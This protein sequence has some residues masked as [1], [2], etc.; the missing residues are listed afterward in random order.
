VGGLALAIVMIATLGCSSSAVVTP[1]AHVGSDAG[2]ASEAATGTDADARTDTG[3]DAAPDSAM[4][5]PADATTDAP[6]SDALTEAPAGDAAKDAG[7]APAG[8]GGADGDAAPSCGFTPSNPASTGL[9]NTAVYMASTD[10]ESDNVTGLYW[11]RAASAST[12]T[13]ADAATLCA[14]KGMGWRLPTLVELASLVDYTIAPPGPTINAAFPGTPSDYFW[15]SSPYVDSAGSGWVINFSSGRTNYLAVG[16]KA[17]VRCVRVPAPQ[18][19]ATRW[20]AQAGGLIHDAIANQTWQ[21]TLDANSYN[22][23]DA[24][25]YCAGLGANWRLPSLTEL[26]TLIDVAKVSPAIDGTIFPGTPSAAFWT[27]S[28][29]AGG[30]N[31]AWA[32]SFYDGGDAVYGVDLKNRVRC[33]R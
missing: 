16:E 6:A 19:P 28:A 33:V 2:D 8:D 1:D 26:E 7:D 23:S 9:P 13:Q 31:I 24:K 27:S 12:A 4:D 22:W 20:E 25:T 3:V 5:A 29:Y 11:E 14:G 17:W 30:A 32:V 18:C 10:T 15:T 21:Q